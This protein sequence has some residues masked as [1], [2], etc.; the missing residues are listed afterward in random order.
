MT[1]YVASPLAKMLHNW[2]A[3]I[4]YAMLSR[5]PPKQCHQQQAAMQAVYLSISARL[6]TLDAHVTM[7]QQS[8]AE[9]IYRP[10]GSHVPPR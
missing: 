6:F 7:L 8:A 2:C 10:N 5:F 9:H 1:S 4:S 3:C